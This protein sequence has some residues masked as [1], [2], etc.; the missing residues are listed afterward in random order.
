MRYRII[1]D[2]KNVFRPQVKTWLG[3][4]N[5]TDTFYPY[6]N[7]PI[8]YTTLEQAMK[9][10]YDYHEEFYAAKYPRKVYEVIFSDKES[11]GNP[12]GKVEK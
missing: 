9:H 10:I 11:L 6:Y 12:T 2:S 4:N 5:F 7:P 8:T 3:W 1:Q